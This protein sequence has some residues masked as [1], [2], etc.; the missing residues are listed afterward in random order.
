MFNTVK[1]IKFYLVTAN[2]YFLYVGFINKYTLDLDNWTADM[3][4]NFMSGVS[5]SVPSPLASV[6]V[7]STT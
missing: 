1:P 6:L 5:F 4:N 3:P 2:I 7:T